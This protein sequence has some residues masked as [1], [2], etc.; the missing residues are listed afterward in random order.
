M[1]LYKKFKQGANNHTYQRIDSDYSVNFFLG[2]NDDGNMSMVLTEPGRGEKIK[3]SKVIDV[4][5][6][7]REDGKAVLSFD[8]L[9]NAYSSMFMVFC[10]DMIVVCERAGREMAIS[11]AIMR[12]RYWLEMFGRKKSKLLDKSEIKGLIGELIVLKDYFIPMHGYKVAVESWMGPLLGHKDFEIEDTWYEVKTVNEN[13]IQVM[14]SSM[15]QLESENEGH[16]VVTR[17]EDTSAVSSLSTNLNKIVIEII[18]II[19]SPEVL[20]AF[21]EKLENVGYVNDP[22]YEN[23]NFN[24]K[25]MQRYCVNEKFPRIRREN[26]SSAISN[27]KYSIVLEGIE[28]FKEE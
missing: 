22:E 14:I 2:Y 15:E 13:A 6:K 9:D 26:V 1:D 8:L 24:F 7:K 19:E 25:G 11:N 18:D 5:M 3:S 10:K 4:T 17:L 12:W 28:V 20:D 23:Y 27:A 16:L 21:R